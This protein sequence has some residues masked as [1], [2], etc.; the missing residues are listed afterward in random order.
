M[1]RPLIADIFEVPNKLDNAQIHSASQYIILSHLLR[2]L[3]RL[4]SS[5]QIQGDL[6]QSW[7]VRDNFQTFIF[8]IRPKTYFSN[9]HPITAEHVAKNLERQMRLNT[10]THF[11]F[12]SV[13]KVSVN[14]EELTIALK[15]PNPYFIT[16]TNHPEFGVL[17][18]NP[19]Q[20]N[21]DQFDLKFSITSG[22]YVVSEVG[23]K[24]ILLSKNPMYPD[25]ND[26]SPHKVNFVSHPEA[27]KL[28]SLKSGKTDFTVTM[29]SS[30]VNDPAIVST[31]PHIG[32]TYWLTIN[33]LSKKFKDK[34]SRHSLQA[35]LNSADLSFSEVPDSWKPASQL[36]LPDGLGRPSRKELDTAW[37]EVN[38]SKSDADLPKSLSLLIDKTFPLKT[39]IINRLK[40]FNIEPNVTE[41]DSQEEFYNFF[42]KNQYDVL[43][44]NN[45]FSSSSLVSNILVTFNESRPLIILEENSTIRILLSNLKS[46][47]E[48]LKRH[49]LLKEIGIKLLTDGNIVPIAHHLITF[50]SNKK[51]DITNWST[52]FPEIAFWKSRWTASS[53]KN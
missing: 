46:E 8:H 30:S 2:S 27:Q 25:G 6:A 15:A 3:I 45:D 17:Y 33:P 42:K 43:Q 20:A 9:G 28:A 21:P 16:E 14:H 36:Y 5:G 11:D 52:L 26:L 12:S 32:F 50:F 10:A 49:I 53:E 47:A 40:K 24:N 23:D 19:S 7:T 38:R 48:P 29:N 41:Y 4:D 31:H 34:K 22:P 1:H 37:E 18:S 13:K 44:N 39:Q 51:I 35:L